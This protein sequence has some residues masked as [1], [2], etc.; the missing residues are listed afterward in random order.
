MLSRPLL[1]AWSPALLLLLRRRRHQDTGGSAWS[2]RG[3]GPLCYTGLPSCPLGVSR[4]GK[5]LLDPGLPLSHR[6]LPRRRPLGPAV[7]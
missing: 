7:D 5:T 3:R 6:L 1:A 2:C 4:Q